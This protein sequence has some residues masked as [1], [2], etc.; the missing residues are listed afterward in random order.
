MYK[1]AAEKD[2]L[3]RVDVNVTPKFSG[4]LEPTKQRASHEQLRWY[5]SEMKKRFGTSTGPS[6]EKTTDHVCNAAKGKCAVTA[7]GELLPCVEIREPMGKSYGKKLYVLMVERKRFE[8][9][10]H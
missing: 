6:G 4:D 9:A 8:V 3:L 2:Y 10:W 7:Y 1:W 5:F